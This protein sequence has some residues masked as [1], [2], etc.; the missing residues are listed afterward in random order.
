MVSNKKVGDRQS[1]HHSSA[2]RDR[3]QS[4]IED[5]WCVGFR[6]PDLV[7]KERLKASSSRR[8][9]RMEVDNFIYAGE[10]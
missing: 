9:I 5:V 1:C 10:F 8:D 2:G 7:E 6:E 4:P 3:M